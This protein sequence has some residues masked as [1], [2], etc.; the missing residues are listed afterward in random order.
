[1]EM[2]RNTNKR[3]WMGWGAEWGEGMGALVIA[4]EM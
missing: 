1:M 2:I 3:E 4:F